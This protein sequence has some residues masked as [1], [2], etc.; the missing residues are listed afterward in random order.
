MNSKNVVSRFR[1]VGLVK[2][3]SARFAMEHSSPEA[4]HE[5]LHE[6]PNA[7][8]K[9]HRVEKKDQKPSSGGDDKSSKEFM[10]HNQNAEKKLKAIS[11][12][13]EQAGKQDGP[14]AKEALNKVHAAGSELH[15]LGV[16]LHK[17]LSA[18]KS[19]SADKE[20]EFMKKSL[21]KLEKALNDAKDGSSPGFSAR[22]V[23]E[24]ADELYG[25]IHR[26]SALGVSGHL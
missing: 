22:E 21:D 17:K 18:M 3:V 6:H 9:N 8:P 11:R 2:R 1:Q 15:D 24:A 13:A 16:Q 14:K 4:L 20:F 26:V 5:Y 12:F 7:D 19:K 25:D 10:R 23:A